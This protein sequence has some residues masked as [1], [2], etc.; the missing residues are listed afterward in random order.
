VVLKK[1]GR[2][3]QLQRNRNVAVEAEVGSLKGVAVWVGRRMLEQR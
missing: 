1:R 3:A 2:Q